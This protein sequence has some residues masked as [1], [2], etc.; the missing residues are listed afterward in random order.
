[1]VVAAGGAKVRQRGRQEEEESYEV[2]KKRG[3]RESK[4]M[5]GEEIEELGSW[6]VRE[7][8]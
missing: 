2:G 3:G 4:K 8:G 7:N 6:E 1:M 5:K